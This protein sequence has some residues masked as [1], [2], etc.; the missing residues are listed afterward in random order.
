M[1]KTLF[2]LVIGTGVVA[3]VGV[4]IHGFIRGI[5]RETSAITSTVLILW[6]ILTV[7][8]PVSLPSLASTSLKTWTTPCDTTK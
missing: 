4:L 2:M 7:V 5:S 6:I 3:F 1:L 8:V